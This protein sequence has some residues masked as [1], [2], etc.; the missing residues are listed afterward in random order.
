MKVSELEGRELDAWVAEALGWAYLD[1]IQLYFSTEWERGGPLI[2]QFG[3]ELTRGWVAHMEQDRPQESGGILMPGT[4]ARGP[5]P[6]IAAMRC[7]VASR[8]GEEVP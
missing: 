7:L 4:H 1:G 5:T 3:I 2:E 8:F 6:L